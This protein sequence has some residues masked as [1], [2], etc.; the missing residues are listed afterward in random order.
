MSP[1]QVCGL[2]I[3]QIESSGRLPEASG[4]E[5][6]EDQRDRKASR[7]PPR[8]VVE[9]GNNFSMLSGLGTIVLPANPSSRRGTRGPRTEAVSSPEG[10]ILQGVGNPERVSRSC[11]DGS[12]GDSYRSSACIMVMD[13]ARQAGGESTR[14]DKSMRIRIDRAVD[15]GSLHESAPPSIA[16]LWSCE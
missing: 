14:T 11:R 5:A 16:C 1:A 8:P 7:T 3:V 4:L 13:S 2:R 15:D 9:R 10:V 12:P 6:W